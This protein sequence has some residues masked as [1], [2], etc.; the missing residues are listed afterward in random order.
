M[1]RGAVGLILMILLTLIVLIVIF[2]LSKFIMPNPQTIEADKKIT[3]EAQDAV[4]R[5]QQKSIQ[6]QTPDG[7]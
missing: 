5:Y 1:R 4:D 7:L 2:V 6:N 3:K